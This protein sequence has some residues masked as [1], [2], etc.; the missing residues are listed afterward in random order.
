MLERHIICARNRAA[1][2]EKEAYRRIKENM[3]DV[4]DRQILVAGV[5]DTDRVL[6]C[7]SVQFCFSVFSGFSLF[8]VRRQRT[9]PQEQLNFPP[10]LPNNTKAQSR[11]TESRF[12]IDSL[13]LN[14]IFFKDLWAL[15]QYFTNLLI[16]LSAKLDPARPTVAFSMHVSREPQDDG[17]T[18]ILGPDTVESDFSLTLDSSP[19]A[20]KRKETPKKV[21]LQRIITHAFA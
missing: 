13:G 4:D 3:E 20:E 10:G 7:C 11:S 14:G 16:F 17:Y 8:L 2:A 6:Y 9:S 5:L 18:L 21:K 15:V 19:D 12:S 1:V